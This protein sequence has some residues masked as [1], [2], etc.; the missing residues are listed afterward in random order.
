M[1]Y[2]FITSTPP[3]RTL[4][5]GSMYLGPKCFF[6]H[7]PGSNE[8][9]LKRNEVALR[10]QKNHQ[11]HGLKKSAPLQWPFA[12]L[13][14]FNSI[15]ILENAVDTNKDPH[16]INEV[17]LDY[18][19][20][21]AICFVINIILGNN[22]YISKYTLLIQFNAIPSV[23]VSYQYYINLLPS[24][25]WTLRPCH[26]SGLEDSCPL[27]TGGIFRVHSCYPLVN[28]HRPWK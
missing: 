8:S 28:K 16:W 20:L 21:A 25:K 7:R 27:K 2:P 14:S 13:I 10:T 1:F 5:L 19:M 6:F 9:W 17:Y 22:L 11:F 24:S 18:W 26:S 23:E 4:V 3:R 15:G 12:H